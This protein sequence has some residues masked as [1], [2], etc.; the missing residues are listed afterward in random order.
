MS[1][2]Q[3]ERRVIR[4][5]GAIY[6][7]ISKIIADGPTR[8]SD[9]AEAAHHVHGIQRMVMANSAARDHPRELRL[10]GSVIADPLP[11]TEAGRIQLTERE[12]EIADLL[13]QGF[14]QAQIA[15]TLILSESTVKTHVSKMYRRMGVTNRVS[16]VNAYRAS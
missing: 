6:D 8:R 4:A 10:L 1:L 2:T 12:I 16:F 13:C 7:Q 15:K 5:A 9:M 3:Q 11:E 14:T